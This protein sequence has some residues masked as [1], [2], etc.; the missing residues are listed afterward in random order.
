MEK[1]NNAYLYGMYLLCKEELE[2]QN[3][4][5][6]NSS[7]LSEK[8]LYHATSPTIA[9]TIANDNIDWR[10]TERSRYG[11]GSCFSPSPKY[12]DTHSSANGGTVFYFDYINYFLILSSIHI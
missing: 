11:K 4:C 2:H 1:I 5:E 10:K 7:S 3:Y 8:I 6:V 12:A 9:K